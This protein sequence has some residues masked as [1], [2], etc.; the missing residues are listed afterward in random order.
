MAQFKPY[1]YNELIMV[2]VSLEDQLLPG[3]FEFTVHTL[4]EHHIDMSVFDAN[5][6]NDETGCRAYNPKI[7]LKVVLCGYARG[8]DTSRRLE[9]A[10]RQNINFMALA[11]GQAPD[12]STIAA[13]VSS[14]QDQIKSIFQDMLLY[15][16]QHGLLGG[17]QFSIDGCKLPSNASKENS[18][19]FDQ[20]TDK[21]QRL[22]K[23]LTEL[24][25]E[26]QQNDASEN[27][28]NNI[29]KRIDKLDDF[30]NNNEPKIGSKGK[31]I[32]SNMTDNE[33][34]MMQTSHGTTQGYN[35]QVIVDSKEQIIVYSDPGDSGQD[36]EHLPAM[37]DGAKENLKAIGKDESC[38]K[39][40]DL[41]CDANYFS[42]S[43]LQKT[44]DEQINA[45]IPDPD[46]RKRDPR[47]ITG[48]AKFSIA[49]FDYDPD[50]DCYTCPAGRTLAL[51]YVGK[52]K[53]KKHRRIYVADE[54]DC[55]VCSHR[56]RCLS[57]KASRRRSLN[58]PFDKEL[59]AYTSRLVAKMDSDAGRLVYNQR[60]GMVEP[61]FANIRFQKRMNRFW[62]R[63][64]AKVNIEW[65]LYCLV[66][67][68]EKC[69]E[70]C[71]NPT[72][73]PVH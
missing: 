38:L 73:S 65:T 7:L 62:R 12:H 33:S 61:V 31:E 44:K 36:T 28:I 71:V 51:D 39:N 41:L 68:I 47:L 34:N 18:G 11:C 4:V 22:E 8:L 46:F 72:V 30:L 57:K 45:Y 43:N 53:N 63:S 64:K 23:R 3:S 24:M 48:D 69:I 50:R 5:Y 37:I 15:C 19:T 35:A 14:M 16:D 42:P 67:N 60:L 59:A 6:S 55:Q 17:T 32:K 1:N 26:H 25:A 10:C 70:Y 58:I 54:T 40:V 27:K 13:F 52:R 9:C 49:D 21:K 66:H 2:P 56:S 20:L 29:Q